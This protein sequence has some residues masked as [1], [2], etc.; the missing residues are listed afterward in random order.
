MALP[1]QCMT[2]GSAGPGADV[3]SKMVAATGLAKTNFQDFSNALHSVEPAAA[4]VH[5]NIADVYG[6][7]AQLT[8]SGMSVDQAAQNMGHAF[9][10][11][12]TIQA[13]HVPRWGSSH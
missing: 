11:L 3:M 4:A 9:T 5:D 6:S 10:T 2:S 1:H 12:S 7:L 8:Q 13:L